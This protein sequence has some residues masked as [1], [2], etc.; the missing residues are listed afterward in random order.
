MHRDA[1][2]TYTLLY[3]LLSC[4]AFN[5]SEIPSSQSSSLKVIA[6]IPFRWCGARWCFMGL[7]ASL[8][9]ETG[10][11]HRRTALAVF[12]IPDG[13]QSWRRSRTTTLWGGNSTTPIECS[14]RRRSKVMIVFTRV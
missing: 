5:I 8:I 9:W 13:G 14:Q 1:L 11:E 4:T 2:T 3:P 7:C 10:G 6:F 12:F